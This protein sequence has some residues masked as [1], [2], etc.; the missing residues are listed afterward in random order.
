MV[1]KVK[2]MGGQTVARVTVNETFP[3]IKHQF[4]T[5]ETPSVTKRPTTTQNNV[6]Q[7]NLSVM[8]FLHTKMFVSN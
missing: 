5:L 6:K 1:G 2:T 7:Y 8:T 3:K 4:R